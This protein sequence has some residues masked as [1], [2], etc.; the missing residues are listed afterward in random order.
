MPL[1]WTEIHD[2]IIKTFISIDPQINAALDMHVPYPENCYELFGFDV[3]IDDM[4]NP[5]LLEVR[6]CGSEPVFCDGFGGRATDAVGW[7]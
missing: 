4:L 6:A 2:L 3:L 7:L 5:W 1:L